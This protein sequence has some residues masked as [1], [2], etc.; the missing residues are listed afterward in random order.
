MDVQ[1]AIQ[2]ITRRLINA[3]QPTKL[4]LFG[5]F[6]RGSA[7]PDSDIDILVIEKKVE[8]KHAEMVRL[9]KTLRGILFPIDVLVVSETEF[10]ERSAYPSNVYYW[11]NCEGKVLYE[12]T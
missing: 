4:I 2:E 12:A 9:R 10:K 1:S 3:A 11:T 8:S 5:S 7:G 6:A